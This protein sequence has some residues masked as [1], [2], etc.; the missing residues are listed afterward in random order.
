MARIYQEVRGVP[1]QLLQ[2]GTIEQLK[3]EADQSKKEMG[4]QRFWEWMGYYYQYYELSGTFYM[5]PLDNGLYPTVTTRPL[6]KFLKEN[7][8]V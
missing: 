4:L 7:P 8:H 2:A 3:T 5:K 1:V 6:E